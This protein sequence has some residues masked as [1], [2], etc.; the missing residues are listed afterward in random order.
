MYVISSRS[1]KHNT[2]FNITTYTFD[3]T[4]DTAEDFIPSLNEILEDDILVKHPQR[5]IG[6][7][8]VLNN[9]KIF[10]I[11]YRVNLNSD[12]IQNRMQRY[13]QS[14]RTYRFDNYQLVLSI[15]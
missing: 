14:Q 11:E 3:V 13:L 8:I 6:T 12:I 7:K 9:E 1:S 10:H 5:K 4:L 15:L 2:K